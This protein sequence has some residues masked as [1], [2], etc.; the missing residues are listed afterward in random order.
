MKAWII[1]ASG[2][3]GR[4]IALR[5]LRDG[6]DVVALGRRNVPELAAW[7]GR[8]G[9]EWQYLPLDLAEVDGSPLPAEAPDLVFLSAI[10]IQGDRTVLMQANFLGPAAVIERA[11]ELMEPAAGRIGVLLGQ[12]A[13]LGMAGLGDLSASQGALWTWCEALQADLERR[14]SAVKLTRLI[15]PRTASATQRLLAER[16]GHR[17]RLR[18]PD[19]GPLIAAVLKGERRGGRRPLGAGLSTLLR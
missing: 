16:S 17:P 5:L 8:L 7:A 3:W 11:I 14:Q 9:R 1:G 12:N 15:P 19:P 18:R 4:A 10:A 2:A 6:H 13:R